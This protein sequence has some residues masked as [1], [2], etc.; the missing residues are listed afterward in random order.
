ML[1][2]STRRN[3]A[4]AYRA[5]G[6]VEELELVPLHAYPGSDTHWT[7][8]CGRE[9]CTWVGDLFYSHLRASRGT[10]RRHTNCTGTPGTYRVLKTDDEL[11]TRLHRLFPDTGFRIFP[12]KAG[13]TLQWTGSP[14]IHHVQAHI[15]PNQ[16]ID[17]AQTA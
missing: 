11:L 15:G 17:F 4:S 13:R 1:D 8:A 3:A 12:T 16:A 14:T 7:L 9:G 2:L 5:V 6:R 10:N